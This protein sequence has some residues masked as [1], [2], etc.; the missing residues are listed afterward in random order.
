MTKKIPFLTKTLLNI[1]LP[2][3]QCDKFGLLFFDKKGNF[4][5]T[6]QNGFIKIEINDTT[7]ENLNMALI[8]FND[9]KRIDLI[10][11]LEE[12]YKYQKSNNTLDYNL[13]TLEQFELLLYTTDLGG[14][15]NNQV[16]GNKLK[17]YDD[18]IYKKK[19]LKYKSKYLN[20][21]KINNI[22]I[23]IKS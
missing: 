11:F 21:K 22:K 4:Y 7:P 19:Y 15:F 17:K 13:K 20:L 12:L 1:E 14:G 18:D 3:L 10:K 23:N 5:I 9:Q 16:N 2:N 6:D 8:E